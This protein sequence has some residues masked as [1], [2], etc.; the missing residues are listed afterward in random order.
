[1]KKLIS[2]ILVLIMMIFIVAFI[3]KQIRKMLLTHYLRLKR[4]IAGSYCL[5]AKQLLAGM[6]SI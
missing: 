5:M 6:G 2:G 3:Q 4:R 1:M